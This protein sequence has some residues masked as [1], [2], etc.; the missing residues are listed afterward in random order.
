MSIKSQK[1]I[2]EPSSK[3]VEPFEI[4]SL[5]TN[6]YVLDKAMSSIDFLRIHRKK[7][8]KKNVFT[9]LLE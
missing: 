9:L 3:K 2:K 8:E 6:E 5:L 7:N 1:M 4:L